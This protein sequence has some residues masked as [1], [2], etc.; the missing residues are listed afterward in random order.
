MKFVQKINLLAARQ[1]WLSKAG[2]GMHFFEE[3]RD[4]SGGC[5]AGVSDVGF[6]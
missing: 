1:F 2:L 6:H 5:A 4:E 3:M